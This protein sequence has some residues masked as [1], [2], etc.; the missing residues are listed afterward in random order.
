MDRIL[1]C[2]GDIKEVR[3]GRAAVLRL[4]GVPIRVLLLRWV[5]G[6]LH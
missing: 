5:L 4:L 2:N 6:W 1:R 3:M